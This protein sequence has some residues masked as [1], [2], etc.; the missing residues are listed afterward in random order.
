M[1]LVEVIYGENTADQ[2]MQHAYEFIISIGKTPIKVKNSPGFVVNRLLVPMLNEAVK[3]L[4]EGVASKEDIDQA[5]VLGSGFP[6]GPF[7]LADMSG[8]DVALASM[9][10]FEK[11][12]GSCYT[13]SPTLVKL[14]E[15]GKLGMKTGEG[16]Y[17]YSS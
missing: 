16:F 10:T 17:K 9:R 3:L 7:V 8:L 11:E 2:Y 14:V 4:D 13:P 12:L 15:E 6:A 1:K 5:A